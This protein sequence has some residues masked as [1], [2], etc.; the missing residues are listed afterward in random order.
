MHFFRT[1]GS[2]FVNPLYVT[3]FR[4]SSSRIYA[5]IYTQ[6]R[7][8]SPYIKDHGVAG[9]GSY[10]QTD[11]LVIST[12]YSVISTTNL[13]LLFVSRFYN[14]FEHLDRNMIGAIC[15]LIIKLIRHITHFFHQF[16]N[17]ITTFFFFVTVSRRYK[18]ETSP[19]VG[20]PFPQRYVPTYRCTTRW[21]LR[22]YWIILKKKIRITL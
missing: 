21:L 10:T 19:E 2:A 15:I 16:I 8:T 11:V 22:R 7:H 6:T 1:N 3:H 9:V 5:H 4:H 14:L 12:T 18:G 17:H 20:R 13:L